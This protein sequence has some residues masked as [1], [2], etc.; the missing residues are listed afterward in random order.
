LRTKAFFT[1]SVFLG[2]CFSSAPALGETTA[3]RFDGIY[4]RTDS[5][6][7]TQH[8]RFYPN[9]IVISVATPGEVTPAKVASWFRL[10]WPAV[11]KGRYS[12]RNRSV[13]ITLKSDIPAQLPEEFRRKVP[14]TIQYAGAVS[15]KYLTLRRAG[16]AEGKQY[17]FVNVRFVK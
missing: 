17:S 11:A 12:I 7:V 16:E 14:G 1:L 3:L 10:D 5:A 4:H 15:S 2:L 6:G 8:F 13:K 9:G